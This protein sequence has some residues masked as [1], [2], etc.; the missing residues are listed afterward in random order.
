MQTLCCVK[1]Q[2]IDIFL[3][4]SFKDEIACTIWKGSC[5]HQLPSTKSRTFWC[6]L[7]QGTKRLMGQRTRC[8]AIKCQTFLDAP[9]RR[10]TFYFVDTFFFFLIKPNYRMYNWNSTKILQ[11]VCSERFS[12]HLSLSIWPSSAATTDWWFLSLE[13]ILRLHSVFCWHPRMT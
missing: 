12:P 7:F 8:R 11:D 6:E 3:V 5:L 10:L 2:N 9:L 13:G 1:P 4:L